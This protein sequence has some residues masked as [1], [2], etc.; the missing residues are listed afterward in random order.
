M[1]PIERTPITV[2]L[3]EDDAPLRA[4]LSGILQRAAECR[5]VGAFANAEEALRA[6]P[7]LSPQVVLMDINLPGM[8]GVQCVRRLAEL[9]PKAHILMLT[10]HEDTDSIFESLSAGASGYLLKPVRAAELLAAVKDVYAGGAPMTSHIARKVVQ[11]FKRAGS[12]PDEGKQL[13]PRE[14]DV[15]DFLVK[16]YSYKEVAEQMGISY[17]T[18]HTHIEHIYQKLHVQ[19]RAQAVAKYLRV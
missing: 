9:V 19:S 4:S 10:V 11:S 1:A 17:S 16:G 13:S 6:I 7:N 2:A 18:V 5:C 14:R 8:D 3:V 12:D 15:L